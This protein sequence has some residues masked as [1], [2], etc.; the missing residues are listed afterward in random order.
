M[1]RILWVMLMKSLDGWFN[2][3]MKAWR[4][5]QLLVYSNYILI[6]LALKKNDRLDHC[7]IWL[8]D[9][10]WEESAWDNSNSFMEGIM[11]IDL[12]L[13]MSSMQ[14]LIGN[15]KMFVEIYLFDLDLPNLLFNTNSAKTFSLL[16]CIRT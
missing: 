16:C 2:V 13:D 8:S 1:K 4:K 10:S 12:V 14:K 7:K 9:V 3:L 5:Q 15:T 6:D 11:E